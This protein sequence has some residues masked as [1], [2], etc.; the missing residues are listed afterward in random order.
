MHMCVCVCV[1]TC[2][3]VCL[4][5]VGK[6]AS[7]VAVTACW[8]ACRRGHVRLW[9]PVNKN[10]PANPARHARTCK[11]SPPSR[12]S[13]SSRVPLP[14]PSLFSFLFSL[15]C[16]QSSQPPN[17]TAFQ[18]CVSHP[19]AFWRP[20]SCPPPPTPTPTFPPPSQ[21]CACGAQAASQDGGLRTQRE[22]KGKLEEGRAQ[23]NVW[24]RPFHGPT[25]AACLVGEGA[26]R[27]W[28]WPSLASRPRMH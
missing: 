3:C 2:V 28:R 26:C 11:L 14:S 25:T 7:L 17:A 15:V 16:T 6:G 10:T 24:W 12:L 23:S 27:R 13:A 4:L 22:A 21:L 18:T 8:C 1:S 19:L 5:S 9:H 20:L